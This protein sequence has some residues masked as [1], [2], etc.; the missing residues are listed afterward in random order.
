MYYYIS[1]NQPYKKILLNETISVV[2]TFKTKEN[3]LFPFVFTMKI[4]P[5]KVREIKSMNICY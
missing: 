3:N 2:D 1:N 5:K 4:L